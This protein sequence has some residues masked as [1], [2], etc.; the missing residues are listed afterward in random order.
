MNKEMNQ[1]LIIMAV[2]CVTHMVLHCSNRNVAEDLDS[3]RRC[4]LC[5]AVG[6]C[7]I[8]YSAIRCVMD[9]LFQNYF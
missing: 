6:R 4:P 1:R 5:L 8:H 7:P 9:A 3:S 2:G